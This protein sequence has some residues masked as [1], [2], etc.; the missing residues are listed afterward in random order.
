MLCLS[1]VQEKVNS[2]YPDIL[3]TCLN[4]S[5]KVI[6][7]YYNKIL[8]FIFK[9]A[10]YQ[11]AIQCKYHQKLLTS[12]VIVNQSVLVAVTVHL[13]SKFQDELSSCFHA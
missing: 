8:Q 10:N 4:I 9:N 6:F 1:V 7:F 13:V 11:K 3:E 5:S 12:F 2:Q